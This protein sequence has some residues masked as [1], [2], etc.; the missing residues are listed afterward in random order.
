SPR[1]L[2]GGPPKEHDTTESGVLR[3][4]PSAGRPAIP[5]ALIPGNE[6][7]ANGWRRS[8]PGSRYFPEPQH[9]LRCHPCCKH[10]PE[11]RPCPAASAVMQDNPRSPPGFAA[12]EK[13]DSRDFR[14]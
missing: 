2:A 10:T 8:A 6:I 11:S 1:V 4:C 7:C 13:Q 12:E 9:K 3:G 5:A 14:K